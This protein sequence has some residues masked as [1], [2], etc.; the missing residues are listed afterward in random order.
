MLLKNDANGNTIQHLGYD[1]TKTLSLTI[2]AND[3][4]T[5][6]VSDD[7]YVNIVQTTGAVTTEMNGDGNA[8]DIK[9]YH[10]GNNFTSL[11]INDTSGADNT[12]LVFRM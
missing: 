1:P 3:S 2:S 10:I 4:V 9:D 7:F 8:T 5:I 6:D 12:V 11:K